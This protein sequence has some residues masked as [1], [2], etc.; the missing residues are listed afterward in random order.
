MAAIHKETL[1][2]QNG[3]E[4]LVRVS[5]EHLGN[6]VVEVSLSIRKYL[7]QDN[8]QIRLEWFMEVWQSYSAGGGR[9]WGPVYGYTTASSPSTRT[10]TLGYVPGSCFSFITCT[11]ISDKFFS[12]TIDID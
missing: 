8:D 2:E 7:G 6:G 3:Q 11:N 9:L 12:H 5:I 4:A 1:I 10:W